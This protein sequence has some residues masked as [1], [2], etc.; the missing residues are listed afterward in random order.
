MIGIKQGVDVRGLQPVMWD[1]IYTIE[2][3]YKEQDLVL[4][5]TA[6]LDGKHSFGSFHY[7]G[8]AIDIRT[9][10]LSDPEKMYE[11]IKQKISSAFDV[12]LHTT[13]IHIEY[14]P[15]NQDERIK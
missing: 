4:V 10:T 11:R 1:L 5:I 7:L 2:P 15:K 3:L 9:N 14:Q 12:I 8:L 13:H 6:A